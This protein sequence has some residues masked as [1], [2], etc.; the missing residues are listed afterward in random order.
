MKPITIVIFLLILLFFL[1]LGF[2]F[3]MKIDGGYDMPKDL[4]TK[5]SSEHTK[6]IQSAINYF[7]KSD[8]QQYRWYTES[9]TFYFFDDEIDN[10]YE[11]Y[12]PIK[13]TY[14]S[15]GKI[16]V[17]KEPADLKQYVN[18]RY[19]IDMSGFNNDLTIKFNDKYLLLEFDEDSSYHQDNANDR[20]IAKNIAYDQML[21]ESYEKNINLCILRIRYNGNIITKYKEKA[22]VLFISMIYFTIMRMQSDEFK[23]QYVLGFIAG[24]D[25]GR[26][27]NGYAR[28]VEFK[29]IKPVD[30][31]ALL[32][33][34][35]TIPFYSVLDLDYNTILDTFIDVRNIEDFNIIDLR[36]EFKDEAFDNYET[37]YRDFF[38]S[39]IR[40]GF[41][42]NT[43]NK[44]INDIDTKYRDINY[45][46]IRYVRL[47]ETNFY[48]E[49]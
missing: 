47:N 40:N 36:D 45:F 34:T 17:M 26:I 12:P 11:V 19:K 46:N 35:P 39:K 15:G 27:R 1:C 3:I 2:P 30:Y 6:S 16:N 9:M 42:N 10:N 8:K 48:H 4:D 43:F 38:Q 24:D 23:N 41:Y 31:D 20:Y 7:N 33:F 14:L 22:V 28:V 13:F 21:C 18:R 5:G 44:I 37:G 29:T 32:T 25:G 49:E